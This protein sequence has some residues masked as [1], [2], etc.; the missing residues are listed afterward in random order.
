MNK[1]QEILNNY[2]DEEFIKIDGFDD[3]VIGMTTDLKLVYSVG[4]IVDILIENEKMNFDEAIEFFD[5]NIER[6]IPYVENSPIL[7]YTDFF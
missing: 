3:A 4:D 2:Q 1:L 6:S 5:Y 7:I